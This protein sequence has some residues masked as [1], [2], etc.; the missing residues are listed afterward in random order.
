[1]LTNAITVLRYLHLTFI[2]SATPRSRNV[3]LRAD[4]HN[5]AACPPARQSI[6][7]A[8]TA[9]P[10]ATTT[11]RLN[12]GKRMHAATNATMA[13]AASASQSN[14]SSQAG[15]HLIRIVDHFLAAT[16]MAVPQLT[17]MQAVPDGRRDLTRVSVARPR[18]A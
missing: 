2:H 3:A 14:S 12:S 11:T 13:T 18:P 1:M 8:A 7:T 15:T 16:R 6:R 5:Q 10:A 4:C 9:A 17:P